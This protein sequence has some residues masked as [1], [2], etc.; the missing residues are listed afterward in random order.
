MC[1]NPQ[2]LKAIAD[3]DDGTYL[4]TYKDT[5]GKDMCI[6]V[7]VF[8]NGTIKPITVY[9]EESKKRINKGKNK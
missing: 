4:L 8:D 2:K 7:R 6:P 9:P 1:S 5:G 3:Q